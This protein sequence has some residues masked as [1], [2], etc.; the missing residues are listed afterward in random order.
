MVASWP[1]NGLSC[2]VQISLKMEMGNSIKEL[3]ASIYLITK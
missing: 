2:S 3:R 1:M